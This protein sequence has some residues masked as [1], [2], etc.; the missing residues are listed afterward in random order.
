MISFGQW[1]L[2]PSG[3]FRI[4]QKVPSTEG[5]LTEEMSWFRIFL[6]AASTLGKIQVYLERILNKD[7]I[8][9]NQIKKTLNQKSHV[10]FNTVFL[11]DKSRFL[12]E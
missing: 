8:S 10:C 2:L 1:E 3:Q 6:Q 7:A 9:R 12:F 4:T 5:M 11:A